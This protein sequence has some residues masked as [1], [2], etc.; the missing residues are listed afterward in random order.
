[1]NANKSRPSRYINKISQQASST[2]EENEKIMSK[3][4][5]DYPEQSI[6]PKGG[7]SHFVGASDSESV[8]LAVPS[9]VSQAMGGSMG[10]SQSQ[11]FL[12]TKSIPNKQSH[13]HT[14]SRQVN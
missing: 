2:N 8:N 14:K 11:A 1:M 9:S 4:A 10:V 5:R 6:F 3:T 13:K 7:S 12:P